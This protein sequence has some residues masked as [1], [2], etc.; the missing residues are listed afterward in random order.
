MLTYVLVSIVGYLAGCFQ[1]SYILG[2]T[3]KKADI[4]T[5]GN[6]NAGASNTVI[7]FGWKY[8]AVVALLDIGKAIISIIAIKI[9]LESTMAHEQLNN[10]LYLNGLFVILGH[11]YPF[12]MKFRGGK[13]TASLIG[14]LSAI[15]YR[16]AIVGI[17]GIVIVTVATGYIAL[18]T[19]ALVFLV[20]VTTFYFNYSMGC[21]MI[22]IVIALLSLYKHRVNIY[23]ILRHQETRLSDTIKKK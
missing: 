23:R 4:R 3:F 10:L 2:K 7:S 13:G 21:V 6:G 20:V 5:L 12:Y 15:D 8:G 11:N 1:S 18:G 16:I 22:A 14:M 19:M 17:L 9:F